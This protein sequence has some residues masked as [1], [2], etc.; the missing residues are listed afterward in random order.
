MTWIVAG[1]I[2]ALAIEMV[3]RVLSNYDFDLEGSK[4]KRSK[5]KN[6]K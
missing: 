2:T 4:N 3:I 5:R 1:F 6:R